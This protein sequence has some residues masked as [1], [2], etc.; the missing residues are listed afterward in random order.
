MEWRTNKNKDEKVYNIYFFIGLFESF[1][2]EK[3]GSSCCYLG[4]M[5]ILFIF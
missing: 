5:L 4:W 2:K 3:E 1:Y